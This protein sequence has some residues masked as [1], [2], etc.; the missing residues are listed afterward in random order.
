MLI[1]LE[2]FEACKKYLNHKF[3]SHCFSLLRKTFVKMCGT[4]K[5]MHARTHVRTHAYALILF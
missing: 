5:H 3:V 1:S 2:S 4:Y